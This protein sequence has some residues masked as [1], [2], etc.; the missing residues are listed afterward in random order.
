MSMQ[1]HWKEM[2]KGCLDNYAGGHHT[3]GKLD[4]FKHGMGTVFNILEDSSRYTFISDL[5][6]V[7]SMLKMKEMSREFII[8][9]ISRT[10]EN[11]AL[12]EKE[13]K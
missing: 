1:A 4:A 5:E 3:D 13:E 11:R 6:A 2:R 7:A 10:L 12:K 9:F 8:E